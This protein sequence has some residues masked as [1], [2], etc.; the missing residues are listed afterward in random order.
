MNDSRPGLISEPASEIMSYIIL[1]ISLF[2]TSEY[3][4]GSIGVSLSMSV[5]VSIR[6][7][8]PRLF[9]AFA[10]VKVK[11]KKTLLAHAFILRVL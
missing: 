2:P 10:L 11:R 8:H 5:S 7:R 3:L 4:K 1:P 9:L 6:S